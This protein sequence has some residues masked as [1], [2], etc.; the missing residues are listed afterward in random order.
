MG[1]VALSLYAGALFLLV[2]VVAPVLLR[3]E[4]NKDVAGSF[5]G[6]I[7]WRFYRIA[8]LLLLVYLI[9]GNKWLGIILIAGLS[10]NVVVSMWLRNY[11]RAL[12]NIEGYDFNSPQRVTFRRVS[13]LSTF[14]LLINLLISTI[15]L[16]KEAV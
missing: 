12:G 13:Y 2:T 3:T 10:L 9:L 16:F 11:K 15:I 7:L 1:F 6:Q 8:F 14:L 4:K 5:Y